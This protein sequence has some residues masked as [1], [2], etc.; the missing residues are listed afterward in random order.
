M[1]ISVAICTWN[2]APLL[3]PTLEQICHLTV[4]AGVDWECIVID[5][6]STDATPAVIAEFAGRLPL[7]RFTEPRPGVSHARNRAVDAA[8]GEFILWTDDD[9]LVDSQWLS[10]YVAAFRA[11]PEADFFGGPIRPWFEGTPPGWLQASWRAV[12]SAFATRELGDEPIS[13][14]PETL[15]YGANFAVRTAVQRRYRYDPG[16]GPR[17]NSEIR[18]EETTVMRAM[19]AAGISGRW[20]PGAAVRHYIPITRQTKRYIRAYYAGQ[21]QVAEQTFPPG[22]RTLLGRPLWLWKMA[23]LTEL[24]Y[25][26]ACISRPPEVWIKDLV[27]SGYHWGLLRG[28]PG[29]TPDEFQ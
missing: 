28:R 22:V 25:R 4:P 15:P 17:P 1:R 20:V 8:T 29:A 7:R 27:T 6:N 24:R 16:L 21:G 12:D 13:F 2:R 18:G 26:R 10:A 11:W 3:R 9:V 14:N 23:V 5:N 19:L